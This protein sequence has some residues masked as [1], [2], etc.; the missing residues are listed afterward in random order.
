MSTPL[1][2]MHF[3]SVINLDHPT[4]SNQ[5]LP[6]PI[7]HSSTNR[8]IPPALIWLLEFPFQAHET[9]RCT[10]LSAS[11]QLPGFPGTG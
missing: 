7:T 5:A 4:R 1:T 11:G 6:L 8:H 10:Q 2:Y 3:D 9:R